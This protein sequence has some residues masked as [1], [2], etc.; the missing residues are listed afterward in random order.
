MAAKKVVKKKAAKAKSN[1]SFKL[2]YATMFNPPES[3]HTNFDKAVVKVHAGLGKDIPMLINGEDR[4][5][6]AKFDDR[7]PINTDW[8][9]GTFQKGGVAEGREALSAARA[10]VP[11]WGTMKWKDRVRIMRRAAAQIEKRL[12]EISA[13]VSLE[14]GKNRM[15]ALGDVQETADLIYYYCDEVE[16]NNGYIVP[17]K[18]DPLVGFSSTNVS[19]LKPY[20][21]WVVISPFNFPFAL[22]GGPTGAALVAG[23]TVVFKPASDTPYSGR[24]LAECIR[25]AGVPDGAFNYVT[26]GGAT[27]GQELIENAEVDGIT[28]TGSYDVGMHIYK[29][30]ATGKHPRPCIAEMGGKNPAIVTAKADLDAAAQGIMRSAFGLQGQKCS[31]CSRIYVENSVKDKFVDKLV[32]LTNKIAIGDPTKREVWLGP[33]ANKSSYREFSEFCRRTVTGRRDSHG[34]P[35]AARR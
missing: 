20:G 5:I 3:M 9:L 35:A 33:V 13:V 23:N 32:N 30:F 12:Y 28:F 17:M 15:E 34:R 10:A 7:S 18:S 4:F 24:L 29:T 6:E 8:L 19:K 25:D 22:A 21:V 16:R 27:I 31:A 14:I 1:G 11:V 2:T 26:G